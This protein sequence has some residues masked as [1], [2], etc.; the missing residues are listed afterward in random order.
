MLTLF[1]HTTNRK[2]YMTHRIARWPWV[3]FKII[4]PTVSLFKCDIHCT[5]M[6]RLIRFRLTESVAWSLCESLMNLLLEVEIGSLGPSGHGYAAASAP[7]MTY[8]QLCKWTSYRPTSVAFSATIHCPPVKFTYQVQS[9]KPSF[10]VKIKM[11]KRILYPSRRRRS[12][13]LICYCSAFS[14]IK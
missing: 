3:T 12:P 1:P 9:V 5:I 2:S 14:I 7:H 6:Q 4:F 11:F 10:H 13:I 8:T